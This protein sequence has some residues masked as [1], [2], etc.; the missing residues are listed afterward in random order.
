MQGRHFGSELRNLRLA[1]GLSQEGLASVAGVSEGQ[2]SRWE[3][4]DRPPRGWAKYALVLKAEWPELRDKIPDEADWPP[5]KAREKIKAPKCPP[6]GIANE[7]LTSEDSSENAE[8]PSPEED[9]SIIRVRG[10]APSSAQHREIR[11]AWSIPAGSNSGSL[12]D[13][14]ID[15][16]V[17]SLNEQI[18]YGR[19][20]GMPLKD[21]VARS[22]GDLLK[23]L[24]SVERKGRASEVTYACVVRLQK[25]LDV[26]T[27]QVR[28]NPPSLFEVIAQPISHRLG[29][30]FRDA[31]EDTI[32]R[33]FKPQL[34]EVEK[35]AEHV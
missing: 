19:Q 6:E 10:W 9:P 8:P 32:Q 15:D 33:V 3:G 22:R 26:W 5:E 21:A 16:L 27:I 4:M 7:A 17:A 2:P 12:E 35:P 1:K 20:Q 18:D 28:E 25:Q 23:H 29:L 24:E 11:R 31:L 30:L 13:S 14:G 34:A